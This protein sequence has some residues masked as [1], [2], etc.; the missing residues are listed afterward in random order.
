MYF[1]YKARPTSKFNTTWIQVIKAELIHQSQSSENKIS[2]IKVKVFIPGIY[3]NQ[4]LAKSNPVKIS[5][6]PPSASVHSQI[7]S[8]L[9]QPKPNI[10][11]SMPGIL[12]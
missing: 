2:S 10:P 4:I 8:N 9:M 1:I 3:F 7:Q 12:F 11:T 6:K 5:I